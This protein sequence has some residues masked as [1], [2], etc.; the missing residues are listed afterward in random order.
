MIRNP[1][2]SIGNYLGPYSR[3]QWLPASR[4]E[5]EPLR[6]CRTVAR[7]PKLGFGAL[8]LMG[9][10]LR[11]L[12]VQQVWGLKGFGPRGFRIHRLQGVSCISH[13]LGL[14]AQGLRGLRVHRLHS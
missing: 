11:G 10:G 1:Q 14:K 12:R 9:L 7:P 5:T 13:V 2:N 3:Y 4:L 6:E 8:G